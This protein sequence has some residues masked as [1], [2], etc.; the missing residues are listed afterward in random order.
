M[1]G[2]WQRTCGRQAQGSWT[3]PRQPAQWAAHPC[4]FLLCLRCVAPHQTL[5]HLVP[6]VRNSHL[7]HE[8]SLQQQVQ[9]CT[10]DNQGSLEGSHADMEGGFSHLLYII[11]ELA[12]SKPKG[13]RAYTQR[14][15]THSRTG[16]QPSSSRGGNDWRVQEGS[17]FRA[18]V[19]RPSLPPGRGSLTGHFGSAG[20][21]RQLSSHPSHAMPSGQSLLCTLL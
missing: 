17:F 19:R 4:G 1:Q 7:Y 21:H 9:V 5:S 16:L 6:C 10:P 8:A 20:L 14:A 13:H 2:V 11:T 18:Q 3:C 15:H 12:N